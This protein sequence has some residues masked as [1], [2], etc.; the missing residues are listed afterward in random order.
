LFRFYDSQCYSARDPAVGEDLYASIINDGKI[1]LVSTDQAELELAKILPTLVKLIFQR[2]LLSRHGLHSDY[3]IHNTE[4]PILFMADEYH[5]VATQLQGEPTGDS[6]F[7]S[8][9]RE[10]RG[11]CIVATQTVKQL[12]TSRLGDKWEAVFGTL[13]AVIGMKS[14]E[15][16]TIEYLQKRA[17]DRD[18]IE[19]TEGYQTEANKTTTTVNRQRIREPKVPADALKLLRQGDAVVI[20]TTTGHGDLA[21]VHYVHVPRWQDELAQP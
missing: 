14:E 1:V 6:D 5:I 15:S 20:G 19:T 7:F 17:G 13:A 3:R 2:T 9:A 10:F 18:V 11:L 16:A 8:L 21:S 12:Q 4:R